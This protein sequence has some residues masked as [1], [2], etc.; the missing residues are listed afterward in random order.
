MTYLDDLKKKIKEKKRF[1]L[2]WLFIF[3]IA[4]A[5][6]TGGSWLIFYKP[7]FK[8]RLIDVDTRKPIEGAVVVAV[9]NCKT[10]AGNRIVGGLVGYR[11]SVTDKDGKF[12]ISPYV[13]VNGPLSVAKDTGFIIYKPGYKSID[14]RNLERCFTS[15]C[16]RKTN[17]DNIVYNGYDVE[18]PKLGDHESRGDNFPH[19]ELSREIWGFPKL[20]QLMSK[21][22]VK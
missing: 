15:G 17:S 11:E 20:R 22:N 9:Y 10:F 5:L 1:L 2:C 8:G 19:V 6:S 13:N 7:A 12:R 4:I 18:L 16:K 21:E 14:G 3:I